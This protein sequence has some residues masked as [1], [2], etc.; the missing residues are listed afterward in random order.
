[1]ELNET[2]QVISRIISNYIFRVGEA[3]LSSE[4]ENKVTQFVSIYEQIKSEL[5]WGAPNKEIMMLVASM[6][7]S[8]NQSFHLRRY[9]T[10][11]ESIKEQVGFFSTLK[12]Y[13]RYSIAALLDI[14]FD[15]P[16]HE[17]KTLTELYNKLI[18]NGFQRGMFSYIAA[19]VF[20]TNKSQFEYQDSSIER[21]HTIYKAMKQHH[22]FLTG[23]SDYPLAVL[24][25]L[26]TGNIDS[27]MMLVESY[28]EQLHSLGFKKGNDLQFLSHILSLNCKEEGSKLTHQ[29]M[30]I[31]EECNR[32]G[33][34]LKPRHYPSIGIIALLN[35]QINIDELLELSENLSSVKAFRWQKDLIFM[36]SV[37]FL[38]SEFTDTSSITTAGIMTTVETLIQAQQATMVASMATVSASSSTSSDS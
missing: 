17:F 7:V 31:F 3:M 35:D 5:G 30:N 8:S 10:I 12:G 16:Q 1:M 15:N 33:L 38:A 29:C 22:F 27:L 24:L 23:Q 11:C 9:I 34:K 4:M 28:Y 25:S 20:L 2:S 32:I 6:Y 36:I 37:S 26:R 18:E 21:A 13:E 19:S 14:H